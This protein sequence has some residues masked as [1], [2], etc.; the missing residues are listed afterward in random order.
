[1][2]GV[3]HALTPIE[4]TIDFPEEEVP[5]PDRGDLLQSVAAAQA[6]VT[7]AL[8]GAEQ[9]RVA[10]EGL[11]CAIVG[12]PNVGKSSLL[13]ALLHA[14]RAIVTPIAGTTRD[15][16]EEI[17]QIGG[18]ACYLIDT[19]GIATTDDPVERIGVERSHAALASADLALLV[20]DASQ[21]LTAAD[22]EAL[23]DFARVTANRAEP[24][25]YLLV[26]NKCDL[27]RR[28]DAAMIDD[29]L[30]SAGLPGPL[31]HI[32]TVATTGSGMQDLEQAI[33]LAA[34]GAAET[35]SAPLV[36][37]ARHR[38]ALRRAESALDAATATLAGAFPLELAAEDLRDAVHALG[39]ITG[40]SVTEDL[41]SSIFQEFC[42]GK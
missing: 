13:N 35:G 26:A 40:E 29:A 32:A 27:P 24:L 3:L 23:A 30:A 22:R 20:V 42:I 7:L 39:T 6:I 4:A 5:A 9:G 28:L 16:V 33:A 41:L 10:R 1:M 8:S 14:D 38:D 2:D 18:I 17:A 31:A 25:R 11:R 19:A 34:H 36:A 37:R 12:R 21:A 15:T